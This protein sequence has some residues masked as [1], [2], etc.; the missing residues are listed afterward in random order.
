M[1]NGGSSPSSLIITKTTLLWPLAATGLSSCSA[2][3]AGTSDNLKHPF[4]LLRI[5][6]RQLLSAAWFYRLISRSSISVLT[7][8]MPCWWK[9]ALRDREWRTN[10][11][12][13]E[14]SI[15][16]FRQCGAVLGTVR[17]ITENR[18]SSEKWR[19]ATLSLTKQP[20]RKCQ[21]AA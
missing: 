14:I 3:A 9:T 1:R 12:S 4:R 11:A 10:Y 17:A 5:L 21:L 20:T 16:E 13:R 6:G 7:C 18:E 19:G 8:W 2:P 15:H